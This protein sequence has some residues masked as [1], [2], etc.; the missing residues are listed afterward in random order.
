MPLQNFASSNK[1]RAQLNNLYLYLQN[2]YLSK[3]VHDLFRRVYRFRN[4]SLQA[5]ALHQLLRESSRRYWEMPDVRN[6]NETKTNANANTN[7][8]TNTNAT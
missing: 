2:V 7:T 4:P 1:N 3:G 5:R 6:G 8:N